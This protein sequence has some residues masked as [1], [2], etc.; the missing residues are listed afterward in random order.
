MTTPIHTFIL[1]VFIFACILLCPEFSWAQVKYETADDYL[2]YKNEFG[3]WTNI[4]LDTS[5]TNFQ[6]YSSRN[7]NGQTGMPSIPLVFQYTKRTLGFKL[8]DAP[9]S[10]DIIKDEQV[11]FLTTKGPYASLTGVAGSKQEQRFNLLFSHTLKNNMNFTLAFNRYSSL[12][13]YKKQQNF[14][15]NVYFSTNYSSAN[16]R[17]GYKAYVLYNKLKH[18]ENGGI[19][20]DTVFTDNVLINK[21]L[22]DINISNARRENRW[23]SVYANAWFRLNKHQD[24]TTIISHHLDYD[25]NYQSEY[26]KYYDAASGSDLFYN[27]YYLDTVSTND[28]THIK[29]LSNQIQYVLSV[30]PI[31]TQIKLGYK[32]EYNI[33]H[34]FQDSV[35]QN[36]FLTATITHQGKKWMSGLNANYIVSGSNTG[37]YQLEW[38]NDFYLSV[39]KNKKPWILS[40]R[41]LAE[42]RHAD[43]IYN[44]WYSNHFVW[45]HS[46]VPTQTQQ[47]EIKLQDK[48]WRWELGAFGQNVYHYLYFDKN[49][50]ATQYIGM[51]QN[52][53]IYL[54][55]DLLL[56]KHLGFDNSVYYQHTADTNVVRM[57]QYVIKSA[58]YYQ[59]NLFKNHLWLQLGFQGEYDSRFT[60]YAYMPALNQYY[61]QNTKSGGNYPYVDFFLTARIRPV[62]FFIKIDHV[63][64]GM[65]G[66]N[67][68]LVSNYIQPDRAF[69]FGLNWVFFD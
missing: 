61:L 9:Y 52:M 26:Y 58:L 32:H 15:N 30:L 45:N 25:V 10:S 50:Q 11:K 44:R 16:G 53:T 42:Q 66:S 68:S 63:F 67:Y 8:Y 59:G 60:S 33:V 38:K 5:I 56:F 1:R 18:Q 6:N 48:N 69:K 37:D 24:S 47:A 12:G 19:K 29:R 28:S 49:A 35:I 31:H 22:L 17:A 65:L 46:F 57:P 3:T 62:K 14:T 20:Y 41:A 55:K 13:F 64:Q 4:P 23:T 34:Q 54:K 7:L 40:L 36:Q 2:K 51:I 21:N 27:K 39:F 43:Y